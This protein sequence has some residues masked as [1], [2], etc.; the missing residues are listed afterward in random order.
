M[1][2]WI[3][4]PRDPLLVRDGRPFSATPG[5]RAVSLN[6]PFPS[7]TTGAVRTRAGRDASGR[8]VADPAAMQAI[9]V[10]GP[11]L[12]ELDD[13]DAIADW[14]LPAPADALLLPADENR[15]AIRH[16]L[17]PQTLPDGAVSDQPAGLA[18][19][20]LAA[21]DPRKPQKDAP[22]FWRCCHF[23]QWL[24]Q[25]TSDIPPDLGHAGPTR[26]TRIQIGRDAQRGAAAD[27][28]LFETSGL[29]FT[30]SGAGP[31]RLSG[32]RRLALAV[33]TDATLPAQPVHDHMGGE[34]RLVTWRRANQ[35]LPACPPEL[36]Q[37]IAA[38]GR[39]RLILLTPACFSAGF[40]PT[41]LL[42]P[43]N[44]VTPRLA[45]I[46]I[47]RAQ[48]VSGWDFVKQEPKPTRRLAP[49]GAVLF[50]NLEGEPAEIANWIK[51]TWMQCVSDSLQDR[52]DG[53]GLAVLGAWSVEH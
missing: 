20:G 50:L 10:C 41:W 35:T 8:F 47:N 51:T 7:T 18:L 49:A 13:E 46:A 31:H 26:E 5:A 29:E 38:D 44:G 1:T 19:V 15:P 3:I 14:L 4:E 53:F 32:A 48:V 23:E 28:A 34:R 12:V 11:L 2:V 27:G 25:P 17:R 39:C 40:R 36:A 52:L 16:W 6:F 30:R 9:A 33:A 42:N 22:A 37:R 43:R 24:H 45:A 21:P